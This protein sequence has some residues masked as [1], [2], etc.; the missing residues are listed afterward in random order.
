LGG[1]ILKM[2]TPPQ[3]RG[4]RFD[5]LYRISQT[6]NSSLDL[7]DVLNRVMDE[8][9]EATGAERGF[10]MALQ[11]NGELGFRVAR[12]IDHQNLRGADLQISKS[13]VRQVIETC[14]PILTKNATSDSRWN[15][16]TTGVDLRLKSIICVP[17]ICTD[18]S[19]GA[20]YVENSVQQGAFSERELELLTA[21]AA[22][23]SVAV[24]NAQ[25]FHDL[26]DQIQTLNLLYEISADL[27]SRLDLD[28]LLTATLQR[29]QQALAAPAASL[30]T[31]EGDELVF[32]VALGEKSEEIKPFRIPIDQGIAGWV[33]Q[34]DQG[35][36]VNN[37]QE[38]PRFYQEAD[39]KS[40][41]ITK[42]IIA[43]PLRVKDQ[44]IGVV[45]LFNKKGGFTQTD[46]ELLTSIASTA[47]IAIDNARLYK[48][49][50]EKGR[51]ERELQMALNVQTGLLPHKIPQLD[52][53]DF[54]A[55]WQPARQ[56]SGDFYDFIHLRGASHTLFGGQP[57]LGMVIADVTDKGMPA[58]LF[59]AFTRSIIR[60]N[61]HQVSSPAEGINQANHLICEESTRG[62][63]VTL[64]YGQLNPDTGDLAY[65]NAGHNPPLF[66][67]AATR[68]LKRLMPSGIPLGVVEDFEYK[69]SHITLGPGDFVFC[70]TDGI[71]EA[72]D[73]DNQEFGLERLEKVIL[74]DRAASAKELMEAVERNVAEF[75]VTD[76]LFDDTTILV[77]KRQQ[78]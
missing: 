55:H 6:F 17:M 16:K 65:V 10:I 54:A 20:I 12:G 77:I 56:V 7:D 68:T 18:D 67:N 58:A 70:Y 26:Q 11:P 52:G 49:A 15:D 5:L 33:V 73:P 24:Q 57:A 25:L 34:N 63:Y 8:V 38:D 59:M 22:N 2:T 61:L 30:L 64:F 69:Q 48:T 53:W 60:A 41:F 23:A 72:I 19:Q 4:Q 42:S 75:T 47:A 71:T 13:I 1:K 51:M 31:I 46:L 29:V 37:A 27:T 78:T 76:T 66:Y 45:E 21:I 50:V 62:L 44:A 36:I 28:Q 9:I 74:A 43:A 32:Q 14:Q 3:S 39:F 40:G 35:V